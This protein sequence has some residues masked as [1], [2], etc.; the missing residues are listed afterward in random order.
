VRGARGGLPE[1]KRRPCSGVAVTATNGVRPH[2]PP[3]RLR[4]TR[5]RPATPRT[6]APTCRLWLRRAHGARQSVRKGLHHP[7]G[8]EPGPAPLGERVGDRHRPAR[9]RPPRRRWLGGAEALVLRE[10]R[11]R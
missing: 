5:P 7:R 10:A 4:G 8:G 11:R 3:P 1:R 9:G 2:A 6:F